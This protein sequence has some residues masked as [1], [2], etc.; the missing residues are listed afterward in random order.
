[1]TFIILKFLKIGFV[2]GGISHYLFEIYAMISFAGVAAVSAGALKGLGLPARA[3][4]PGQ[5]AGPTLKLLT[6]GLMVWLLGTI[7]LSEAV[8]I[9]MVTT[10]CVTILIVHAYR[11][12]GPKVGS[13]ARY[14]ITEWGKALLPFTLVAMIN[15]MNTQLSIIALGIF[16]SA[17]QVAGLRIAERVGQFVVLPMTLI[18]MIIAPYLVRAYKAN[19]YLK[20]QRITSQSTGWALMV[21]IPIGVILFCFGGFLIG[22]LF[23]TEYLGLAYEPMMVI[24]LAQLVNVFFGPVGYL[25]LLTGNEVLV[26]KT[27]VMAVALSIVMLALLIPTYGAFGAACAIAGSVISWNLAMGFSVFKILKIKPLLFLPNEH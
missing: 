5:L 10:F 14:K 16:S 8:V 11:R 4:M 22:R 26:L 23:G 6:F 21:S 17:E 9:Q 2:G 12:A 13:D 24:I 15:I 19:D 3:E 27:Q 25:L 7:S 20:M 1:M 18:N